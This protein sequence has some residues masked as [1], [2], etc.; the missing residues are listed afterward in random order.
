MKK[1]LLVAG[2]F[3][4]VLG[5]D[6]SY[7]V[8]Q[9]N[10][11]NNNNNLELKAENYY[12]NQQYSQA[13]ELLQAAIREYQ[14]TQDIVGE[15]NAR[16]NLAL[17]YQ[18]TG[19]WQQGKKAIKTNLTQIDRLEE[20]KLKLELTA[21]S[22]EVLG[23]INLAIGE[24]QKAVDSWK[25]ATKI[26]RELNQKD[27]ENNSTINLAIAQSTL[28]LY[29][30]AR[31]NLL[32]VKNDLL[33]EQPNRTKIAALLQL[34][35]ILRKVG[36]LSKA[37]S[38]LQESLQLAQQEGDSEMSA[39]ILISLGKL[40]RVRRNEPRSLSYYQQALD[41]SPD[42]EIG[43]RG[44]LNQLNWFVK[45][46]IWNEQLIAEI[47]KDLEQLPVSRTKIYAEIN[48]ANNVI[49]YL[50]RNPNLNSKLPV[51]HQIL[52]K[53]IEK[54]K[55]IGDRRAESYA[56]GTL[57]YLYETNNR[58][59]EAQ[60]LTEKAL[61]K[62]IALNSPDLSYQWEWQLGRILK[63][64]G[65]IE[66][67]IA[68]Y[69]AAVNNLKLLRGDL[70]AISDEIQFTFS[71]SVEPVY[72]ELAD[73][74]LKGDNPSQ[75][76]LIQGRKV[77]EA[78]QIAKLNNYF[79]EACLDTV[80]QE[81]DRLDREAS[82]IYSVILPDRL[83]L[84]L[85]VPGQPLTYYA[86]AFNPNKVAE[87]ESITE[88][89]YSDIGASLA[90]GYNKQ[91]YRQLYDLLIRPIED[92][93]QENQVKTLVFILD[94]VLQRVPVAAL[95]DGEEYLIEK[96][97]VVLTPGLQLLKS[98]S[99]SPDR[100]RAIF[101]GISESVA[102]FSPLPGVKQEAQEV[103]EVIPTEIFLNKEFTSKSLQT[104]I[105]LNAFPIVHLA[106]HGQ[107]SSAAEETFL[108]AW[109]RKINVKDLDRLLGARDR[110]RQSPIELLILSACETAEGDNRAALGIA[111]VAV[112]SGARST[113]A[114]LWPVQ[115][116][117]TALFM[118]RLYTELN[119]PGINKAEALRNAQLSLLKESQF[120]QPYFWAGFVLIGNWL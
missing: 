13:I 68:A 97:N 115:D 113:I 43:V 7:S 9:I 61:L 74:L 59:R 26:Y 41:L 3:L 111:G 2:I 101:A 90:L 21:E 5:N 107:F 20:W 33:E 23:E 79:R 25:K 44:R 19:N 102:G 112:R 53:A 92:E 31:E 8:E 86:S 63:R 58:Y 67:A 69:S 62:A 73:L 18:E 38:V 15:I 22:I 106:T 14:Q 120:D 1:I 47:K 12:Q 16:R 96:Y 109:D 42:P 54:A 29:N 103:A 60:T 52:T 28:G 30:Q 11:E 118:D 37:D 64:Q 76:N 70:V 104:E 24:S 84:I 46:G 50:Q 93:L 36:N 119:K 34:G 98:P 35:N 48:L 10:L 27:R 89:L 72:R 17:V 95:F 116:D 100:L 32:A 117:S 66:S 88:N 75:K 105:G 40:E 81:I 78:L 94:G 91:P 110:Q 55:Q 99:L 87:I 77:I 114:T 85:S 4:S 71:E 65:Q 57:G 82:V 80:P 83:A 49:Q 108:L 45:N 56:L 39:R 51:A 6:S